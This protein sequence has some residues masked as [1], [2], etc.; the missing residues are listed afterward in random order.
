MDLFYWKPYLRPH[1][2]FYGSIWMCVSHRAG[3]FLQIVKISNRTRDIQYWNLKFTY[4]WIAKMLEKRLSWKIQFFLLLLQFLRY[5]HEILGHD[6]FY[7][8]ADNDW[9]RFFILS[10]FR[11]LW[12]KSKNFRSSWSKKAKNK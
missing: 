1:K 11:K 3:C 5:L 7:H 8:Y 12:S 6:T 2:F 4:K 10:K 9:A